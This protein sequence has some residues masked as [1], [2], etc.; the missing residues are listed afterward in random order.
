MASRRLVL[1]GCLGLVLVLVLAWV[2][3]NTA[4]PSPPLFIAALLLVVA[5]A[6]GPWMALVARRL[7][8]EPGA[9]R[10]FRRAAGLAGLAAGI[11]T[12]A[13]LVVL[14]ESDAANAVAGTLILAG[15]ALALL[16]AVVLPWIFLLTRTVTRE[17]AARVR[18]EERANVAAHLHDS[19]LQS[20][21]LIQKQAETAP[22]RRLA[23]SAERELRTWLYGAPRTGDTDFAGA[24]RAV[25][26]DVEDRFTVTV[27]LV[28]VGTCALHEP[29][30]AVVG[31]VREALTNAAKHAEVQRVSV[32]TEVADAAMLALVRDRGRGFDP[33]APNP[34]D[35]RGI[36]DSIEARIRQ[37]GG[38]AEV[39]SA[40][41]EGTEV[42]LRMPLG[43]RA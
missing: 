31:A 42:E 40:V 38:T 5:L 2:F 36:P 7:S 35:R 10:A 25:A 33:S 29:A 18:A 4:S 32:F 37:Q 16:G 11:G 23:R 28:S 22:A 30:L 19:V 21:T 12:I 24:V 43:G 9:G 3:E 6:V 26:D 15:G 13:G 20:L 14:A 17:R 39:R 34:P 41:G 1:L 8:D 27:E